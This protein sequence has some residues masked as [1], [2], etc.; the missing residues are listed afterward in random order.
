MILGVTME[1]PLLA[2]LIAPSF[3]KWSD[4]LVEFMMPALSETR[5]EFRCKSG[6]FAICIARIG[7]GFKLSSLLPLLEVEEGPSTLQTRVEGISLSF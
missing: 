7:L 5:D 3:G 6:G 4:P 2:G 1:L